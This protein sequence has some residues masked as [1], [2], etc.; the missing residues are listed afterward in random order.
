MAS[1]EV[2][3]VGGGVGHACDEPLS[4]TPAPL[5]RPELRVQQTETQVQEASDKRTRLIDRA[6]R[7]DE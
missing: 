6:M 1:V 4:T 3:G 7:D 2:V 5:L